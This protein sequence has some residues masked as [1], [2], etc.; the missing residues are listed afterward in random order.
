[1]RPLLGVLRLDDLLSTALEM[2]AAMTRF[3]PY[4]L[5]M[6]KS[7]LWVNLDNLSLESAIDIEDHNQLML[8]FTEFELQRAG[9]TI[10]GLSNHT[11]THVPYLLDPDGNEI[12]VYLDV[13]ASVGARSPRCLPVR[14]ARSRSEP[15]LRSPNIEV[16]MVAQA[17]RIDDF[18]RMV[19]S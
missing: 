19:R 11:V 4:G 2:A 17:E 10:V 16:R 6:T 15:T 5:E 7:I 18:D 13:P 9:V 8:G 12:E 14:P 3:S 1:M